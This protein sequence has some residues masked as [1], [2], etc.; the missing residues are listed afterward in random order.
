MRGIDD[1]PCCGETLGKLVRPAILTALAAG[2]L[3]GYLIAKRIERLRIS[4]GS[5]P[6]TTGIYRA[7]HS[8]QEDDFVSARWD[9]KSGGPARRLYRLTPRGRKCLKRWV[10]TLAE[11]DAAIRQLLATARRASRASRATRKARS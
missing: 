1:C 9:T 8:M 11:H 7:L 5:C 2:P 4:R 3:H 10:D 6:D